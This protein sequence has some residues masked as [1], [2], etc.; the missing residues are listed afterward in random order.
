V[1]VQRIALTVGRE[2]F[3]L[4][5]ANTIE[6]DIRS[7]RV[8]SG[9]LRLVAEIYVLHDAICPARLPP[10]NHDSG[11]CTCG[12]QEAFNALLDVK[13]KRREV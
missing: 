8:H 1:T 12:G 4:E 2:T 11:P 5:L 13:R 10:Y 6:P 3:D 7:Y 9:R